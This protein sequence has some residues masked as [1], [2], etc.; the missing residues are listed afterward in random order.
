MTEFKFYKEPFDVSKE[1]PEK[2]VGGHIEKFKEYEFRLNEWAV[3]REASKNLRQAIVVFT[4]NKDG[5]LSIN[6]E[7]RRVSDG[8]LVSA[9]EI[10]KAGIIKKITSPQELAKV[11]V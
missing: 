6:H 7:A 5:S 9:C 10:F 11:Q 2:P 4:Y 8:E 1:A 3:A